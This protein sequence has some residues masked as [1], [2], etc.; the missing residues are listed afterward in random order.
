MKIYIN[1]VLA[2]AEDLKSLL[3]DLGVQLFVKNGE[4]YIKTV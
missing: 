1:G 4:L 3:I 2:T